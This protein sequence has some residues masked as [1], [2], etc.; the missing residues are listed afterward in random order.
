MLQRAGAG[1]GR[2]SRSEHLNQRGSPEAL[3]ESCRDALLGGGA[4]AC[5]FEFVN[6]LRSDTIGG[7]MI[8][9]GESKPSAHT[10]TKTRE[11]F[12]LQFRDVTPL[13]QGVAFVLAG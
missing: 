1:L 8:D 13:R 6:A 2:P 9:T 5:R 11:V 10:K 4:R 12:R 3:A 7:A